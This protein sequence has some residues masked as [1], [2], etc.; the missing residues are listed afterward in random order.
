M[1]N[2][3]IPAQ[4]RRARA[5][6]RLK[7]QITKL[8]TFVTDPDKRLH[9]NNGLAKVQKAK[10]EHDTLL[11]RMSLPQKEGTTGSR[12]DRKRRNRTF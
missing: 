1:P 7:E 4:Q 2:L 12:K 10:G 6:E 11:L 9:P 8:Q 5:A 3:T